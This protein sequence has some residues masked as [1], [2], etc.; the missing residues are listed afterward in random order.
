MIRKKARVRVAIDGAMN[1][2]CVGYVSDT[3]S[4]GHY[5]VVLKEKKR[6]EWYLFG[7]W[8]LQEAIEGKL[9]QLPLVNEE[10]VFEKARPVS[11]LPAKKRPRDDEA[12]EPDA[13]EK[14]SVE[15]SRPKKK[16]KP[17]DER[18]QMDITKD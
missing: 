2:G 12:I 5:R 15:E 10:P 3:N 11:T 1:A 7:K 13:Q 4:H 16:L 8:W 14:V 6:S 17:A 9:S 18:I